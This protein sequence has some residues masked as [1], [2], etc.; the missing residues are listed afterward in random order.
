[1]SA[2]EGNPYIERPDQMDDVSSNGLICFFNPDRVCSSDCMAF[3]TQATESPSLNAQQK[4][5]SLLVSVERVG[6]FTGVLVQLLKKDKT[7]AG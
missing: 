5:C 2:E 1:M 6:R 4:H 7:N 3:T